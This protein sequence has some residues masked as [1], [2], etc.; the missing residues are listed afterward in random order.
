MFFTTA[1]SMM[2][3]A[4][5]SP[6]EIQRATDP[7]QLELEGRWLRAQQDEEDEPERPCLPTNYLEAFMAEHDAGLPHPENPDRLLFGDAWTFAAHNPDGPAWPPPADPVEVRR[8]Q[9]LYL[10][11]RQ[12]VVAREVDY[13]KGL[14]LDPRA[15]AVP[16]LF[17]GYREQLVELEKDLK[18]TAQALREL[19]SADAQN[20]EPR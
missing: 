1:I 18:E 6:E 12:L 17:R 15:D 14:L 13:L 20:P 2:Q 19:E 11:V 10:Q 3:E 8:L 16:D 7:I 5:C 9:V 4:G